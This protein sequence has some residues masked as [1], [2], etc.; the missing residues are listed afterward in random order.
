MGN[1]EV[2][3]T[4]FTTI[5]ALLAIISATDALCFEEEDVARLCTSGTNLGLKLGHA[6]EECSQDCERDNSCVKR[7]LPHA[8]K[9]YKKVLSLERADN[10]CYSV[11]EL[12]GWLE[13]SLETELC[14]FRSLGWMSE[15]STP[16]FNYQE[17]HQDI[18]NLPQPVV[19]ALDWSSTFGQC[20]I[21]H[22]A[23][24]QH[25]F[26]GCDY[27]QQ[28][29]DNIANLIYSWTDITCFNQ[30]FTD[31]CTVFLKT[32]FYTWSSANQ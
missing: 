2:T 29:M 22:T 23:D 28:E 21:N 5:C 19:S 24:I 6:V 27:G 1:I 13:R 3:V 9:E 18:S 8:E 25:H 16:V 20:W 7:S 17:Y 30:V 32:L 15:N 10:S 11:E 12:Q 31:A 4:M 26:E 14:V